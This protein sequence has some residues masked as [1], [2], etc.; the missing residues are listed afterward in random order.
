MY[1]IG[2][3]QFNLAHVEVVE[4]IEGT[5]KQP[6]ESDGGVVKNWHAFDMIMTSGRTERFLFLTADERDDKWA[7]IIDTIEREAR[8]EF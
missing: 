3:K 2:N 7:D 6:D 4:L 8:G 1:S 5:I